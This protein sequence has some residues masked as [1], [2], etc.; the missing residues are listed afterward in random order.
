MFWQKKDDKKT[1]LNST[2]LPD[3]PSLPELSDLPETH[4]IPE[5]PKKHEDNSSF[6]EPAE[7]VYREDNDDEDDEI[8]DRHALPSF[9]DSPIKKGFSQTAIKDAINPPMDNEEETA[10][11]KSPEYF[12]TTEFTELPEKPIQRQMPKPFPMQSIKPLPPIRQMQA[13]MP[14]PITQMPKPQK[15]ENKRSDIFIKIDRFY[16]AK[17]ALDSTK[18]K[19]NEIDDMLKKIREVKLR[20]DQELVFWEKEV[21]SLKSRIKEITENIFE[22]VE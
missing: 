12:K 16:S 4:E 3:L 8:S 17:R 18:L 1:G 2:S 20:E 19:L 10:N 5:L 21:S 14:M 7:K 11:A 22:K 6:L 15:P 13:Q 9:P